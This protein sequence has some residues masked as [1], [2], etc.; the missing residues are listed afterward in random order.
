[1]EWGKVN[2]LPTVA[3]QIKAWNAAYRMHQKTVRQTNRLARA[4]KPKAR[5]AKSEAAPAGLVI[6]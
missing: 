3:L 6:A 4:S 2:D 5:P 1:M